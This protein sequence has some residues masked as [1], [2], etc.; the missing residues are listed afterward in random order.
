MKSPGHNGFGLLR[1]CFYAAAIRVTEHDDVLHFQR[2]DAEFER[3]RNAVRVP[4]G[5]VGRYDIR[6]V[7]HDEQFPGGASRK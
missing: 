7:A 2:G 4:V 3:G 5:V 6:H 1:K